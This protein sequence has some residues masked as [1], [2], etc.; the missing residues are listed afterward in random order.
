MR[1]AL[2]RVAL[3]PAFGPIEKR[4][5]GAQQFAAFVR[6]RNDARFGCFTEALIEDARGAPLVQ[7]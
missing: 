6:Q 5:E 1:V 7:A 4:H 3:G 2:S